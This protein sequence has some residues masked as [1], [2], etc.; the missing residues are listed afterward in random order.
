MIVV[1]KVTSLT[2]SEKGRGRDVLAISRKCNNDPN[3]NLDHALLSVLRKFL[4]FNTKDVIKT[5]PIGM[6]LKYVLRKY[7]SEVMYLENI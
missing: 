5:S 4:F 7:L 1:D 6:L 3:Y 2:F